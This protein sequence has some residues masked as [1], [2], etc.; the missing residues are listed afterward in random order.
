[1]SKILIVEDMANPRKA[2]SIL[3]KKQGMQA[4]EAENG[5][6][7]LEKLRKQ[8][9]DLVITDLKMEPIDGMQ[10]L[11]EA[12]ER[13]PAGEV[14]MLTAFGSIENSVDAMKLGAFDYLTKPF[15]VDV[16]LNSVKNAL[17]KKAEKQNFHPDDDSFQDIIGH[18]DGI[19]QVLWVVSQIAN[20]NCTILITG[21]SGTGKELIA[22]AIHQHSY[23][24]NKPMVTV[25]CVT[26]A[27]TLLESELFGHVRGAFT[28]AV[29]DRKGLFEEAQGGTI[30][31]DEIGDIT[32]QT[33]KKLLRVLQEGE[34]RRVGDNHPVKVDV[35]IIVATN[36]NLEVEVEKGNFR[37]D[38]YYRL[39]VIP[40][41]LPPLRE[42]REDIPLLAHHFIKKFA[43]EI[44]KE[45]PA[46]SKEALD[47]LAAYAWPGNIRELE[48][49]VERTIALS[50]K[51]ILQ[52]EDFMLKS[53][54][55]LEKK[56]PEGR[57]LAEMEKSV[58]LTTLE[59]FSGN[60]KQTAENLGISLTT[61]WRK[62][63]A[64]ES[65][66]AD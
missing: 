7:A 35:R 42:R 14:I 33:Q 5:R 16:L 19:N 52:P 6:T 51:K 45:T 31:L 32:P 9:Y 28:G 27:E 23:R 43:R 57:T 34:I 47:N 26:L 65:Q 44:G 62:L 4:D 39:N 11:R 53:P 22:R 60:H 2:L 8:A 63:K 36:K 59:A 66:T 48:N 10:V 41:H 56:L 1:M 54:G 21:E 61:L 15:K 25:N 12:K 37:E 29:R 18:S 13:N 30:F 24:H 20:T 49:I 3:L 38:L 55:G 17:A 50:N 64:Y 58:I 40:V 46:L